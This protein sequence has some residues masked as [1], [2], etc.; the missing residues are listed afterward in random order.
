MVRKALINALFSSGV[1][2]VILRVL[3]QLRFL[4]GLRTT[5]PRSI[6]SLYRLLLRSTFTK[7]V[8]VRRIDFFNK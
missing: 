1:P 8:G 4:E 6:N 3:V 5:I 7:K 2:T